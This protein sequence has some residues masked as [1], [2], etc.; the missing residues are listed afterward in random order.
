[1]QVEE[2]VRIA[3]DIFREVQ[4]DDFDADRF[5]VGILEKGKELIRKKGSEF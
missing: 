4:G 5:D 2:A 1:M 3:L